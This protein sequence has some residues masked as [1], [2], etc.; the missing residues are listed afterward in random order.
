MGKKKT[1]KIAEIL[2]NRIKWNENTLWPQREIKNE[3]EFSPKFQDDMVLCLG[4]ET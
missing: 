2:T 4:G 3:N 1:N